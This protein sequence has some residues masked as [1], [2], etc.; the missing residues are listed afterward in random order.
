M[1]TINNNIEETRIGFDNAKLLKEK[2]FK[3]YGYKFY[4]PNGKKEPYITHGIEYM[5]DAKCKADWNTLVPYPNKEKDVLC[6]A[7]TQQLAID[8]IRVNFNI[9]IFVEPMCLVKLNPTTTYYY[10]IIGYN[11]ISSEY[12]D[13][14][15]EAIEA[16]ITDV[17]TNKIK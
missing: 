12:Y 2:G 3:V 8:W 7:P 10:T 16:A 5:S 4:T 1:Q 14:I 17:L 13:K 6:S 11:K 15:E 9:H